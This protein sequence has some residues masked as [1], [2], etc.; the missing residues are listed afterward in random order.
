MVSRIDVGDNLAIT[1]LSK[2]IKEGLSILLAALGAG[3]TTRGYVWIKD[4]TKK[5]MDFGDPV[6][7]RTRYSQGADVYADTGRGSYQQSG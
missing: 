7:Q 6:D 2:I 3:S 4:Y 1:D 5:E